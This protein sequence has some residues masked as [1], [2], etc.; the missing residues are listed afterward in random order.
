MSTSGALLYFDGV[1]QAPRFVTVSGFGQFL[2][3]QGGFDVHGGVR[4][5]LV[6]VFVMVCVVSQ[7][8]LRQGGL[9]RYLMCKNY[10][11]LP[12]RFYETHLCLLVVSA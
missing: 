6:V 9:H 8:F 10:Q 12:N 2:L 7:Y 4:Q 3:R 1:R 11:T 5:E